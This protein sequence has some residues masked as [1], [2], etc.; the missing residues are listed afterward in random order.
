MGHHKIGL[1]IPHPED[2]KWDSV[3]KL[4]RTPNL[5]LPTLAALIP[6]DE[7]DIEIQDEIVGPLDFTRDYDLVFI[8]VT[9]VV[10][11]RAYEV[12]RLFRERGAK[13]VLGGIH[14]S[15]LPDEA[16]KHADAVVIGEGELTVP[17]LLEDF[18]KGQMQPQYRMPYMVEKWDEKP[19]R[20]DLLPPG[21][22][23]RDALTATRGCNYR[24]TFCSIHLALGGGQ[25]GFR[26][27]P[28]AD[29][30]KLVE[31]MNGPMV[32]FWDDDLLSDPTYTRELCAAMKPLGKKWMSQMSATYVAHHPE[33]LKTLKEAGCSAMFMGIESINQD[34]LKSVDKQNQA[35]LYEEM[36]KRIHDHGIDIHAGFICGLDHEDVFDFERTAEWATKMGLAGALWRI[37]TPY[38]GTKQFAELKAAGRILTENWTAYTG[39]H[40]VYKPA[41]MTVE[42]LYWGHKWAKG[43]FYSFKSIGQRAIQRA[44][45]NGFGELL[46]ITGC[47]LGYRSMFHLAADSVPVNVYRDMN[48][49][50]PQEEPIAYRFPYPPKKRFSFITDR[51]DQLRSK[52]QPR[53]RINKC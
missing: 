28:P 45:Q 21:Y 34:S 31:K 51:M 2:Q 29:V 26:K 49:L 18:K 42:Q 20:W 9:T 8:T 43:Q 11:V 10:A 36:I 37:M 12:A 30:V 38:P 1:I 27:K 14:P 53:P 40:V 15:T 35:K 25:Y 4:F 23:F 50:P 44:S 48:H 32:M 33:L 5:N 16:V 17:R 24:C 19:P 22:M 3:W 39:E 47:G 6:E 13:V 52:M 7:W 41:K 46:N